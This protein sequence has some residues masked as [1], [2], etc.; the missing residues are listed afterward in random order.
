MRG[1]KADAAALEARHPGARPA[2]W[3]RRSGRL[4]VEK[5]FPPAAKQRMDELVKNVLA[6]YR[7][8]DRDARLDGRRDQEAGAG[9]AG[10]GHAEDRLSRQMAR[11][12]RRWRF[13]P[14]L[15]CKNV[16]RAEAFE[17]RYRLSQLGKPVDRTRMAHDA[18]DGECVLQLDA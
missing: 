2:R 15:T 18:A 16:M 5:Y 8:A 3:A 11:L 6:V 4:Y 12:F 17:S 13:G 1:V 10:G 9:Q 7:G 14:I